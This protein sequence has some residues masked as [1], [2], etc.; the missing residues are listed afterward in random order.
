MSTPTLVTVHITRSSIDELPSTSEQAVST[1][2]THHERNCCL[3]MC[4][5][6]TIDKFIRQ[7][8]SVQPLCEVR[9]SLW[10]AQ[11]YCQKLP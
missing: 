9:L 8:L 7:K 10:L 1:D 11:N 4:S 5:K 6:R 3:G 2:A